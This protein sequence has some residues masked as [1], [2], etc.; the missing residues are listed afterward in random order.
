[1]ATFKDFSG[2]VSDSHLRGISGSFAVLSGLD[3][4]SVPGQISV[5]QAMALESALVVTELCKSNACCIDGNTYFGSSESGK[6][7]KRTSAG[8]YTLVHTSTKGNIL[9]MREYQGYLYYSCAGFVGRQTV[10]LAASEASWSSHDDDWQALSAADGLFAPMMEVMGTLYIGNGNI[11]NVWDNSAYNT[12]QLTLPTNFR[13]SALAPSGSDI[14][15]GTYVGAGSTNLAKNNYCNL[16]KWDTTSTKANSSDVIYEAGINA[17]IPTDNQILVQAGIAGNIYYYDGTQLISLKRVVG[18]YSSVQYGLV[19]ANASGIF[20]GYP[21]F[22]FSNSPDTANSTGNPASCG[23]YSLGQHNKNYPRVL[24]LEYP[25]SCVSPLASVEIGCIAALGNTILASWK[26]R[27]TITMTIADPCVVTYTAHGLNN[28]AAI[29]FTTTGALPTGLTA[30][31]T[32]YI[33]DK[34]ANSFNLYA[35]SAQGVTGGATGRIATTVTQSGVHTASTFGVDALSATAKYTAAYL[36]TLVLTD[37]NFDKKM[38]EFFAGYVSM[39][40]NCSITFSYKKNYASSYTAISDA[41]DETASAVIY[42][43]ENL[44]NVRSIQVKVNFTVSGNTA[45]ALDYLGIR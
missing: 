44:N 43:K 9:S 28:G 36:E 19:Y 21:V 32:Y 18:T 14:L 41:V 23:I 35:T 38:V 34:T 40:T 1:M 39:P 24:N 8:V 30:G 15:V 7:W 27:S 4:H 25:M 5:N 37:E 3:I 45:P 42:K 13:I 26:K 12:I 10:A 22:G 6:I 33:G 29:V 11:L 17:F 2:G 20:K 31:T 16:Y